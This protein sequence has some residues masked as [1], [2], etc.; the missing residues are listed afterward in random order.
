M[1]ATNRL[2]ARLGYL[3]R[4]G[5]A[6]RK[7]GASVVDQ[8]LLSATSFLVGL[9]LIRHVADSE[10]GLFVLVQSALLLVTVAHAA[11][12]GN[13]LSV[14]ASQKPE[15]E[16][17]LMIASVDRSLSRVL[18]LPLAGVIATVPLLWF[19]RF[20]DTS[21]ALLA[22]ASV[23]AGW[24]ALRRDYLRTVALIHGLPQRILTADFFYMGIVIVA[25]S[26]AAFGA[27]PPA[28]W[29]VLG[30][31]AGAWVFNIVLRRS[32]A[33]DHHAVAGEARA[34]WRELHQLG[35][36][37]IVGAT[38]F[39]LSAQGFN[40]VLAAQ[41]DTTAVAYV[42]AVR[43]LIMPVTL[44]ISGTRGVLLPMSARWLADSGLAVAT[45][46]TAVI[47]AGLLL[48]SLLYLGPLWVLRDWMMHSVLRKDI[49][50]FDPLLICWALNALVGI[51]RDLFMNILLG[52]GRHRELAW[53]GGAG[54]LIAFAA[55][56]VGVDQFGMIGAVW[57]L[58][59]G[60][61]AFLICVFG[62]IW[63]ERRKQKPVPPQSPVSP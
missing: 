53:Y 54:S 5:G 9:L 21:Q 56:W 58:L 15:S 51:V 37:S 40:Y 7:V 28:A 4:K 18:R 43:L 50:D 33:R 24:F 26:A 38:L 13:P 12:V 36:W 30:L 29:A 39:W 1:P 27:T 2:A 49:N 59:V 55:V 6:M 52:L 57:G 46:R 31:A 47:C 16:R 61:A 22:M 20:L 44:L 35:K 62:L 41:L 42:N 34:F 8:A 60:D 11:Y 32:L 25:A 45:R 63:V 48:L 19:A 17:L 14:I 23:F 3:S 10:Y